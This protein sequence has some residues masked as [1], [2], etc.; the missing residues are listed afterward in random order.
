MIL[1]EYKEKENAGKCSPGSRGPSPFQ[2]CC[3]LELMTEVLLP[4]T[5]GASVFA[6]STLPGP[7]ESRGS[8]VSSG[9]QIQIVWVQISL[10][11]TLA[12]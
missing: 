9:A 1:D 5:I 11:H 7:T 4:Q 8:A 12:L 3:V 10:W 6:V 2:G